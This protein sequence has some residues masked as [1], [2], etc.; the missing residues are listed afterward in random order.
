MKNFVAAFH[1]IGVRVVFFFDGHLG[2]DLY[3]T[4][5][6]RNLEVL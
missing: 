5:K 2:L 6:K 1:N 3:V 4:R